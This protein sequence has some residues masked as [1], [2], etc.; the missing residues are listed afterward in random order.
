LARIDAP[1]DP[2]ARLRPIV[3]LSVDDFNRTSAERI[4]IAPLST[5]NTENPLAVA[6]TPPEGGT[7]VPTWIRCDEMLTLPQ[8]RL[9]SRLGLVRAETM[10]A[11]EKRMLLVLFS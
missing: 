6:M 5:R 1:D 7:E 3:V 8:A 4:V 10:A 11:V 2:A 9:V